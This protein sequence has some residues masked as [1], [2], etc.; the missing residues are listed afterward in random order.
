MFSVSVV[1]LVNRLAFHTVLHNKTDR[2][3]DSEDP[4]VLIGPQRGSKQEVCVCG[5]GSMRHPLYVK[6]P[7]P[8][9]K[10]NT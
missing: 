9:Q 5:G 3:T 8:S 1:A 2:R 6:T 10:M 7:T 4:E